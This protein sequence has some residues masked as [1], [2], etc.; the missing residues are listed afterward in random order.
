MTSGYRLENL[1][2]HREDIDV[3]TIAAA[4]DLCL[5]TSGA[6]KAVYIRLGKHDRSVV[7]CLV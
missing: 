3:A 4:S 5:A 1:S 6:K 7:H 2:Y